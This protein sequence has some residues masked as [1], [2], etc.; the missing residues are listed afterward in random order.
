MHYI[1]K[2]REKD[3]F[4]SLKLDISK[5][6]DRVDWSFLEEIIHQMGFIDTWINRI[7]ICVKHISFLVLINSELKGCIKASRGLRQGDP[8]TIYLFLLCIEGLISLLSSAE[9]EKQI[10]GVRIY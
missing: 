6:Y 4:M 3:G 1:R 5:A 7:M 2:R 10:T 8:L 9:V